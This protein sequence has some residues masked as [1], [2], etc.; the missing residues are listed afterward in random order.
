MAK[1]DFDFKNSDLDAPG[2][3]IPKKTVNELYKLLNDYQGSIKMNLNSNKMVFFVGDSILI[4]KLID[5]NFP[6][7]KRVIPKDN[8]NILKV[9]RQNFSSAVDRVSTITNDKSPVIKF[10]L[11][12]NLMN[13]SSVNVESGTATEDI[14]T[15]Y[16]GDEIEIGFNS[17]YMLEMLNS[18]EDDK[19]T[20]KFKDSASPVIAIEESNPELIYVLMPMR[21]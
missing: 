15:N 10:K 3:I 18:L 5:G 12:N 2:V 13:M 11:L 1:F 17:K 8:N 4:T 20:L 21:V 7:Y 14:I 9:N 6:D 19:I 16:S